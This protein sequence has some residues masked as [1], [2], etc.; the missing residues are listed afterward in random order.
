MSAHMHQDASAPAAAPPPSCVLRLYVARGTPNSVRAE[1]NLRSALSAM[2]G[3]ADFFGLE[4]VD[5]FTRPKLA[6]ADGVIVTPT[7]FAR[8]SG[9]RHIIFG[10]LS[11]ETKLQMFFDMLE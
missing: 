2:G 11:N 9:A 10:D 4:I 8:R 6:I 7:L 1:Q 5:V 3:R